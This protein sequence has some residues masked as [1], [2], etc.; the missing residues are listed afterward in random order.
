MK[1][2]RFLARRHAFA[3]AACVTPFCAHA[4]A[5][6]D[7]TPAPPA[8]PAVVVTGNPLHSA[9]T[10]APVSSLAG[11][12]LVLRRGSSLGETLDGLPGVASTAFGPNASRPVIRG[13]DGDRIRMLDN[14]G[15]SLDASSLSFDHAVPIDPLVIERV[16]VLRGPAALLYGGSAIGGVV[17][18]LDNRIPRQPASGLSGAVEGRVGGAADERGGAAVLDAG[19]TGFAVHADAFARRTDDLHVPA[20]E[21][22]VDGGGTERRDRIV[23]SASDA[24]GGALGGSLL[25]DHGYL[26]ASVDTY[27]NDYGAVAEEDVTIRMKRDRLALAGE[28]RDLAGPISTVRLQASA[29]DYQ[30]QEVEGTGAVGTTFKN[31][32]GD[33]RLEAV[34]ARV[35]LAIGHLDGVFGVQGESSRFAA[36]G[37]EAF[38]P[39]THTRQWA[40]FALEQ[41]QLNPRWQF[42]GG[43]RLAS[44]TVASEGDAD[45]AAARFGGPVQRR[46]TPGSAA[47]GAVWKLGGPWQLQANAAYT[48]RAPTSY[49]LYADGVHA[50]TGTY[51]R[52]DLA[53]RMER[54][55]NLDVAVQWQQGPDQLKLSAYATRFSNYLALMRSGEPDHVEGTDSFPVYAFE[56]VRARLF[57]AELE[58][59]KRLWQGIAGQFDA[60]G[61]VDVVRGDNLSAGEPLP[62]LPPLRATAALAWHREAWQARAEVQRAMRQT[63]VPADDTA[64]PGWTMVNLSAA[65][66]LAAAGSDTLLFVR[67]NNLGNALAYNASSI[68]TVRSIAPLAGRSL[69]AGMRVTF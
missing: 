55:R 68:A 35:P 60:E 9:D 45:P 12:A 11:D 36:L 51:E 13:L 15:A 67:L 40:A 19:G 25:W 21:R 58:G 38:V 27:R 28:V 52:G 59:R 8:L 23:N 57:G 30:H 14:G 54:G 61:S 20:F 7:A 4:Q 2:T 26:G 56:G 62:R 18:T 37:E 46:F 22:P 69:T 39:T 43:V 48:E 32:G 47:L 6:A 16:E 63:R 50:A 53:Q 49:E 34:H 10:A 64:T 24:K 44:V 66:R 42:N 65:Y 3:A 33:L 29:A 1:P 17:N 5:T 41:W 31:R